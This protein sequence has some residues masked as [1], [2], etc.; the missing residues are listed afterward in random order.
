MYIRANNIEQDVTWC[1]NYFRSSDGVNKAPPL[2]KIA[3]IQNIV[4]R[5]SWM[6]EPIE[7]QGKNLATR[8]AT[9]GLVSLSTFRPTL[10]R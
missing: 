2:S 4:A 10:A 5:S 7:R 9:R 1:N 8:R 3:H 6:P